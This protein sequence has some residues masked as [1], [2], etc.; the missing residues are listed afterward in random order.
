MSIPL[1][2]SLQRKV[3]R[4]A[5]QQVWIS[6]WQKVESY[7][8]VIYKTGTLSPQKLK[9]PSHQRGFLLSDVW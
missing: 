9:P 1:I 6:L 7:V 2:G 8:N 5:E 3:I 4:E